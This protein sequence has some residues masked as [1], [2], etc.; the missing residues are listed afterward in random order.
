MAV[1]PALLAPG[2]ERGAH[3]ALRLGQDPA[4]LVVGEV[5]EWPPRRE[6]S[7]PQGLRLPE[8]ADARDEA[9]VE[10]GVPERPPPILAA[11]VGEHPVEVGLG[12]EDVRP[13][14]AESACVELQDGAAPE[15]G[16]VG[17][18]PQ[19]EPRTT[20][21]SCPTWNDPPAP[22]HAQVASEHAASFEAEQEVLPH[23]LDGL[24]PAAVEALRHSL[25]RRSRMGRLYLEPLTYQHGELPGRAMEAV[26][27]WHAR[28][29]VALL[30][31]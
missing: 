2:P 31:V 14:A 22:G 12:G 23:R 24:E 29:T 18:A 16:L 7:V 20:A 6:P 1:D 11:K 3:E 27:F 19:D 30:D 15:D 25:D 26:S 8:I 17:R 21:A 13:E 28:A 10:Q 4:K 9:L 5:A